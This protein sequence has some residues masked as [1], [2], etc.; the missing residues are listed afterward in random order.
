MSKAPLIL[1]ADRKLGET[2]TLR[3]QL[4]R[5]GATVLMAETAEQA[6][7]QALIAP[8]DVLLLDDDLSQDGSCDLVD[9]FRSTAP[10]AEM[11]L[12]SSRPDQVTRGIGLGL[13]FHGLRPVANTTLLD[14]VEQALPG[15]LQQ[16]GL[17]GC[18]NQVHAEIARRRGAHLFHFTADQFG[19]FPHHAE[20]AKSAC[21]RHRDHQLGTRNAAHSREHN[22]DIAAEE[23]AYTGMQSRIH[24]VDSK[25]SGPGLTERNMYPN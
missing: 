11:I 12:L 20:K 5:R 25:L 9:Y 4:R 3:T 1:Q 7:R 2:R 6:M 23:I 10:E 15:R 8:P 21:T 22:R 18:R 14:L 13:L 24:F 19:R 17:G 16:I